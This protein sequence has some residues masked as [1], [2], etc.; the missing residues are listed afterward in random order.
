MRTSVPHRIYPNHFFFKFKYL[1]SMC[2]ISQENYSTPKY[3]M[4]IRKVSEFKV[5]ITL[6][7]EKHEAFNLSRIC[8]TL[9]FKNTIVYMHTLALAPHYLARKT[10]SKDVTTLILETYFRLPMYLICYRIQSP[11]LYHQCA[12]N[13]L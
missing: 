4:N 12:Q 2:W 8:F 3:W 1:M 7:I 6:L 13:R 11:L 5:W 10:T 9:F